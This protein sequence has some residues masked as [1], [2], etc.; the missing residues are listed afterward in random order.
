[1]N[2]DHLIYVNAGTGGGVI[3]RS[4][5]VSSPNGRGVKIGPPSCG[6]GATANVVVQLNTMVDN[7]GPPNIQFSCESQIST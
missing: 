5:L 7:L 6:A 4:I 2:Q 3:E 1:M